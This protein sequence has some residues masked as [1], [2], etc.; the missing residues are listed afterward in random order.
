MP[1]A[2]DPASSYQIA[3]TYDLVGN[4]KSKTRTGSNA[5]TITYA[6]YAN[7]NDQLWTETSD[8]NPAVTHSYDDNGS[9]TTT[10]VGNDTP[11]HYDYDIAGRMV[12]RSQ[13]VIR[14]GWLLPRAMSFAD[15]MDK[16]MLMRSGGT[17][18]I[19]KSLN[20]EASTATMMNTTCNGL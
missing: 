13:G 3:Y 11:V 8:V 5:E 20:Q 14:S 10:T 12:K 1:I 19:S 17:D 16:S 15:G 18:S 2:A 4:R 7:G 6:Y 9:L